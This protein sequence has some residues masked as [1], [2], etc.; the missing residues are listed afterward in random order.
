M[1]EAVLVYLSDGLDNSSSGEAIT[2][3]GPISPVGG[4]CYHRPKPL[5]YP[6]GK[7]NLAYLC[8]DFSY[9]YLWFP[10]GT[11]PEVK[12]DL[13]PIYGIVSLMENFRRHLPIY[14]LNF[15]ENL[16]KYPLANYAAFNNA[17]FDE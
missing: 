16:K 11:I 8:G 4:T 7:R 15:T 10:T 3:H 14:A 9:T 6:P 17:I 2:G 1:H 5:L 13:D 12:F